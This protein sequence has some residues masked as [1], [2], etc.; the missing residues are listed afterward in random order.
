MTNEEA[1]IALFSEVPVTFMDMNFNRI[2]S[3]VYSKIHDDLMASAEVLDKTNTLY[4]VPL[5]RLEI[6]PGEDR[7]KKTPEE[8]LKL[9]G[10]LLDIDTKLEYIKNICQERN[11]KGTLEQMF[12][13]L[14]L[15]LKFINSLE[16][17]VDREKD[18]KKIEINNEK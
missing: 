18:K 17:K 14:E 5:S 15:T 11:Y 3:L 9:Q 7:D 12:L 1:K 16:E 10:K 13:L 6:I 2:I 4:R 8:D